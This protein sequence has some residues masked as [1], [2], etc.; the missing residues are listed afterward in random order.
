MEYR[1]Y[2]TLEELTRST[3]ETWGV[4]EIGEMTINGFK[5]NVIK[6]DDEAYFL[7]TSCG[8][9]DGQKDDSVL[10]KVLNITLDEAMPFLETIATHEIP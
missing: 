3:A 4:E 7:L 9:F 1:T 10:I 2:N 6:V 5:Y 8:A